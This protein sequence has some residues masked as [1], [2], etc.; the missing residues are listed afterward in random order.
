MTDPNGAADPGPPAVP[1]T[2]E[3]NRH[4]Y[5]FDDS[6]WIAPPF[7]K[8][9]DWFG[10]EERT[11]RDAH[12]YAYQQF[13]TTHNWSRYVHLGYFA[14][15]NCTTFDKVW[16]QIDRDPITVHRA[17]WYNLMFHVDRELPMS[18]QL[19]A[20]AFNVSKPYLEHHDKSYLEIDTVKHPNG[21][22]ST[23]ENDQPSDKTDDDEW[24]TVQEKKRS[25]SPV[26]QTSETST[27]KRGGILRVPQEIDKRTKEKSPTNKEKGTSNTRQQQVTTIAPP[28]GY[29]G[30]NQ[31]RRTHGN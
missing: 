23:K 13:G 20:W 10:R 21:V 4:E 2:T 28:E 26:N 11:I 6:D 22:A 3:T 31:Y 9:I 1:F 17:I 7:P 5:E 15:I 27:R 24:T 29:N 25:K 8:D 12:A 16:S 18:E 19:T 14:Y 30:G